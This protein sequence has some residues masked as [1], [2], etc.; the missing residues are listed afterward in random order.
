M[1]M[2]AWGSVYPA[3]KYIMTD[4]SPL[5]MSFLRYFIG[6]VTLT[7]FFINEIRKNRNYITKENLLISA[8][9]GLFGV[10]LL[11]ILLFYGVNL[12]TASN[13]SI[14]V[15]TQPI[16]LAFLAPLFIKESVSRLQIIGIAA[17]LAGMILV[18]T[19]G[20]LSV[21]SNNRSMFRGN[22]LLAGASLS[23]SIYSLILKKHIIKWGGFMPT[24]VSMLFGTFFLFIINLFSSSFFSDIRGLTA[25]SDIL[26][27]LYLGCV[28]TAFAYLL[29]NNSLKYIDVVKAS[30]FKFLVPVSGV[31]LS[32]LFL[33]ERPSIFV[34]A[35]VTIVILSIVLI[36]RAPKWSLV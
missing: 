36:Q 29:F 10:T 17:G 1:A 25:V 14:I 9:A 19:N 5:T 33:G 7:P 20:D 24:Y 21:L 8:V 18:V 34:Y 2:L 3:S 11:A 4:T 15:N 35:G 23:M 28:S 12:S 6:T 16:F 32:I 27:I 26:L 30:G 31:G 13:G 22:M